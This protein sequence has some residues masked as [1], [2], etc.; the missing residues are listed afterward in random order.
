M[1]KFD[2][3]DVLLWNNLI[4]F[5]LITLILLNKEQKLR[6]ALRTLLLMGLTLREEY[7]ITF[8]M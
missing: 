7:W 3:N 1:Y 8:C 5:K 2:S 4:H 6:N